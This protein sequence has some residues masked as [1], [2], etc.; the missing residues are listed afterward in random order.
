MQEM[1]C[2]YWKKRF[3]LKEIADEASIQLSEK[4]K[5]M[6]KNL[7]KLN[8]MKFFLDTIQLKNIQQKIKK[9]LN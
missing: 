7:Q 8:L 3:S 9:Y 2:I 5:K 4:Q 1:Q 6:K